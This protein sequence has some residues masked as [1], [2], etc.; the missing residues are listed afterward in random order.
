[1]VQTK[2]CR[3][4]VLGTAEIARKNWR[5]MRLAGNASLVAVAS[6]ETLRAKNFI[7]GCQK[8]CPFDPE[9]T[10]IGSYAEA[11]DRD[12]VDAIYAPLPTGTR[13]DWAV[14]A[15]E[16]GKHVL[17]EKPC[18]KDV[19][20]ADR[21]IAACRAAGVQFMD[22]AMFMHALRLGAIRDS[23]R[24]EV[25]TVARMA[26]QFSFRAGEDFF[27]DNI[28]LHSDLE[29]LGCL[30]DLGVYP[31]MFMLW[32]LEPRMPTSVVGR[33]LASAQVASSPHPVPIAFA[34]DLFF[35][36]QQAAS[37][38]FYCS[39]L[40]EHQQWVH[41]SG[42]KG[43]LR[44]DDF[45]LPF[46]GSE[47]SFTVSQP[48]FAIEGCDFRMERHDRLVVTNEYGNGHPTAPEANLFRTFSNLV[49]SGKPD[50]QWPRRSLA[51]HRV[52]MAC[53]E[54]AAQGG[55]EIAIDA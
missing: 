21:I 38:S 29:P 17:V 6:R 53:L 4:A 39:F 12:D 51:A 49:L 35:S 28:R 10:A 52:M 15:A 36:D 44:I 23:L 3:W 42:S 30:G 46:F 27:T 32:A 13:G 5:A 14:R 11:I 50:D 9:P 41:V 2:R 20:D 1:M 16:R 19:A 26:S 37:G 43:C 33:T 18:G 55:K 48:V 31:I 24:G 8:E 47:Q 25:G 22:G 40:A 34:G 45:V 7:A 54:S